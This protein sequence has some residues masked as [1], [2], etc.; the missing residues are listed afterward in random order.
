M[1]QC[2]EKSPLDLNTNWKVYFIISEKTFCFFS[3]R[4]EGGR[5]VDGQISAAALQRHCRQHGLSEEAAQVL[6]KRKQTIKWNNIDSL[7]FS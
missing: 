1:Q 2:L 5:A 3:R 4:R 7:R 6:K